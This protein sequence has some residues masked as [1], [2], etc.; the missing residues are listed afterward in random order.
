MEQSNPVLARAVEDAIRA[1]VGAHRSLAD[2][3][4][5]QETRLHTARYD[6]GWSRGH[7]GFPS[8]G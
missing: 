1:A 2:K 5:Q 7:R 3:L 6:A 4:I 8:G